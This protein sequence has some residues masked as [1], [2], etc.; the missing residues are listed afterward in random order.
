MYRYCGQ[1]SSKAEP[2]VTDTS[3]MSD[4]YEIPGAKRI[5]QGKSDSNQA[6]ESFL[7]LTFLPIHLVKSSG[8]VGKFV[9]YKRDREL[10]FCND[11]NRMWTGPDG[12]LSC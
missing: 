8:L 9:V 7:P 12:C 3:Q 2:A 1:N 6:N 4:N 10:V 5:Q 11:V